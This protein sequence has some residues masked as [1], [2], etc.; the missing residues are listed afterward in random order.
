MDYI[1]RWD[2]QERSDSDVE[3]LRGDSA[4]PLGAM[5]TPVARIAGREAAH[6]P[7]SSC[8]E[9][10]TAGDG[11]HMLAIHHGTATSKRMQRASAQVRSAARRAASLPSPLS[12]C[13]EAGVQMHEK[14]VT[15]PLRLLEPRLNGLHHRYMYAGGLCTGLRPW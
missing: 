3:K 5:L 6:G 8:T 13:V 12:A 15:E 9:P 7:R 10:Y 4:A 1:W 14:A 11:S 2:H